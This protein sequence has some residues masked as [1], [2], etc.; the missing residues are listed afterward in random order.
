LKNPNVREEIEVVEESPSEHIMIEDQ[1][2]IDIDESVNIYSDSEDEDEIIDE[3]DD[4][5]TQ[6]IESSR[7]PSLSKTYNEFNIE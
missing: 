3:N 6:V 4:S 7:T 2:A 1:E 5:D